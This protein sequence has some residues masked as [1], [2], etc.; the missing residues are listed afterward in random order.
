MHRDE[1]VGNGQEAES[2]SFNE[3]VG[4]DGEGAMAGKHEDFVVSPTQL[5]SQLRGY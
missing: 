1:D 5:F 3:A 4:D 2:A